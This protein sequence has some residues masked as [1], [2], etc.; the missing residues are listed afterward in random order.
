MSYLQY[1][2]YNSPKNMASSYVSH[3]SSIY[4]SI[5]HHSWSRHC[6]VIQEIGTTRGIALNN[7]VNNITHKPLLHLTRVISWHVLATAKLFI[8]KWVRWQHTGNWSYPVHY[9][10]HRQ[11]PSRSRALIRY[12]DDRLTIVEVNFCEFVVSKM[13]ITIKCLLD[14]LHL[15]KPF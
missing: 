15:L 1:W 3:R 7:C 11:N 4:P 8:I 2:F 10:I 9:P 5:Y 12:K 6:H 14:I 13:T